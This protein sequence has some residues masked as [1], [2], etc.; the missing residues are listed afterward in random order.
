MRPSN[1][2]LETQGLNCLGFNN[3]ISSLNLSRLAEVVTRQVHVVVQNVVYEICD[4]TG[5][6]WSL[7]IVNKIVIFC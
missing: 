5:N 1:R 7:R 2:G 3:S 4:Y 6:K